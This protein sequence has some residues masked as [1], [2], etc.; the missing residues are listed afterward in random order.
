MALMKVSVERVGCVTRHAWAARAKVP[1]FVKGDEVA[2][3][4]KEVHRAGILSKRELV[5]GWVIASG[6]NH[7]V[8]S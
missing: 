1:V 7:D 8:D 2:Y 5:H 3:G 6:E 4:Y